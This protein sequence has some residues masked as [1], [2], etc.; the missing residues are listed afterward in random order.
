[1]LEAHF[2][3]LGSL[4]HLGYQVIEV[5]MVHIGLEALF[6][7]CDHFCEEDHWLVQGGDHGLRE[8]HHFLQGEMLLLGELGSSAKQELKLVGNIGECDW[9]PLVEE[10]IELEVVFELLGIGRVDEVGRSLDISSHEEAADEFHIDLTLF[11]W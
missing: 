4:E 9:T 3:V 1:M 8:G 5:V 11:L 2:S 7:S 10:L 6:V